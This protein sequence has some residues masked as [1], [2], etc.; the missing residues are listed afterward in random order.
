MIGFLF[1]ACCLSDSRSLLSHITITKSHSFG[2]FFTVHFKS[3][4]SIT[5]LLWPSAEDFSMLRVRIYS[6]GASSVNYY[7]GT[8]WTCNF[9]GSLVLVR[10]FEGDLTELK[11]LFSVL[12]C[13]LMIAE[14][15]LL[16]LRLAS[17]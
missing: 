2:L 5:T 6:L 12:S 3:A 7:D 8:E 14:P 15:C 11:R 9:E 4:T 10:K 1:S 17:E 13:M 16:A